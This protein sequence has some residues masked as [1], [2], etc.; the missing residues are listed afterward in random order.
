[1]CTFVFRRIGNIVMARML[2][3]YLVKSLYLSCRFNT[4]YEG[5]NTLKM[6]ILIFQF[7]ELNYGIGDERKISLSDAAAHFIWCTIHTW[8][9]RLKSSSL[10]HC[11]PMLGSRPKQRNHTLHDNR[12]STPS[13]H[14]RHLFISAVYRT[15]VFS[16]NSK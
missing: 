3:I 13:D 7:K 12:N 6:A 14:D 11:S 8:V 4:L 9:L 1:M 15:W 10:R 2:T 5:R 16:L